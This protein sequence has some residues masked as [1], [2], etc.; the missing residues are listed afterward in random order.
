MVLHPPHGGGLPGEEVSDLL[1]RLGNHFPSLEAAAETL[2]REVDLDPEGARAA[3]TARLAERH[4]VHLE[5]VADLPAD[6]GPSRHDAAARRLELS[7]ALPA[8]SIRFQLARQMAL[9][10]HGDLLA[11]LVAEADLSSPA[12]AALYRGCLADYFAG[13]ALMPYEPFLAAARGLRHD[14]DL[15]TQGF[16]ASLEQ[17]C[18]RLTTLHRPGAE[19]VPFH[20]LRVDIAGNIVKR[21]SASGLRLP[22]HGG[23][24]PLWN[25]HGAFMRP[26]QFDTQLARF[27]DGTTFLSVARSLTKHHCGH[28]APKS[29]Y[30]L[31]LGCDVAFAGRL[32]YADGLDLRDLNVAV[33]VGVSCRQCERSDCRQ[34]AFPS[35]LL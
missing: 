29:H 26:G 2:C 6:A 12:A 34:R 25:V 24:C 35:V 13:A 1:H 31:C 5:L 4:G 17:V 16:G 27:P 7:V 15:L 23:A 33:P 18:H 30:A 32:V 28:L 3:L 22:R 21:F 10:E 20:F 9:L 14:L 11:G 19:G 8:P